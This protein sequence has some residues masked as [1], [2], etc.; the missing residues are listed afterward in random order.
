MNLLKKQD[1][2]EVSFDETVPDCEVYTVG[3]SHNLAHPKTVDHK[4]KLPFQLA[5]TDLMG[6]ITLEAPGG[7][8]YVNDISN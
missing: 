7:Y 3:K 4:I 8:K 6:P 1:H 2:N 5:S